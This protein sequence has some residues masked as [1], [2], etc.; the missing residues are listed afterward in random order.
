MIKFILCR[1]GHVQEGDRL[2]KID[3]INL[4]WMSLSYIS[5]LLQ[6][7]DEAEFTFEYNVRVVSKYVI[8][9]FRHYTLFLHTHLGGG[10]LLFLS[11]NQVFKNA[12]SS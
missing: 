6:A 10:L 11:N 2:L 9:I 7:K 8:L 12:F 5:S 4:S 3:N 1:R